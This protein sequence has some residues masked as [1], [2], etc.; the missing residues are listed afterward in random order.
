MI[1]LLAGCASF[2]PPPLHKD[3][4]LLALAS[5]GRDPLDLSV[6]V[7]PVALDYP[8]K[9]ENRVNEPEWHPMILDGPAFTKEI[10]D[11]LGHERFRIFKAV[12]CGTAQGEKAFRDG[13]EKRKDLLLSLT[14]KR[15]KVKF[16]GHN[17]WYIPT[18]LFH[19]YSYIPSPWIR[20]EI[21]GA[22]AEIEVRLLSVGSEK[23]VFRET[24]QSRVERSFSDFERGW[25]IFGI[26]TFPRTSFLWESEI[27]AGQWSAVEEKLK[28]LLLRR[29]KIDLLSCLRSR[30]LQETPGVIPREKVK[31]RFGLLMS[32]SR[33]GDPKIGSGGC[34]DED[35]AT[36]QRLLIAHLGVPEK[37]LTWLRNEEVTRKAMEREI[38]A[39]LHRARS[40]DTVILYFA[41]K[42][43]SLGMPAA[44][45]TAPPKKTSHS[46]EKS[47]S[48]K[49]ESPPSKGKAPPSEG[50]AAPPK[51][52]TS[53]PAGEAL[54][55]VLL[56]YDSREE[57]LDRS[58]FDLTELRGPLAESKADSI[59]LV[60]DCSFRD[61]TERL[62]REKIDFQRAS[63]SLR[64][65]AGAVK[66][67]RI[68]TACSPGEGRYDLDV[69][70]RGIFMYY[71]RRG[72]VGEGT[73]GVGEADAGKDGR[74]SLRELIDYLRE[75][76]AATA[77]LLGKIQRPRLYGARPGDTPF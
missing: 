72:L 16:I 45:G 65:L 54:R 70:G 60:L 48:S 46:K 21:F 9:N 44:D 39:T 35:A 1:A 2:E 55:H 47:P 52:E 32:L 37:N 50:E 8:F 57:T 3:T 34:A 27:S 11:L 68:I 53:F 25:D 71:L 64:R 77:G 14:V 6:V 74:I 20:D 59:W 42:G 19:F 5:R 15:C 43:R 28:P 13:W 40:G 76:V 63:A 30:L 10:I 58:S 36:F 4:E 49:G 22:E 67:L 31:T 33:Y 62:S 18:L 38:R 75:N 73:L 7:T 61:P 24:I 23:E 69:A 66:G 26:V 56:P 17:G 29:V 51:D 12:E 41:G